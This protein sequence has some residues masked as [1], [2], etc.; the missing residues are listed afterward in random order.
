MLDLAHPEVSFAIQAGE[1]AGKLAREVQAELVTPALT[2]DDKSPVTVADYSVQALL[3]CLLQRAFPDDPLVGEEDAAA[4]REEK[5]L[6][7]LDQVV[8]FVSQYL[9]YATRETVCAWLDRGDSQPNRRFWTLD[10]IDGTKGFLRRDQYAIALALIVDGQVR[11][12]VLACPNLTDAIKPEPNGPG[13]LIV[14]VRG[15]GAWCRALTGGEFRELS[16]DPVANPKQARVLRS[17]ESGHT[18]VS[19]MDILLSA[20]GTEAEPVLMDSQAKYGV[21]ASGA[22]HLLLRLLSEKQPNYKEMIW[23]QAAGS[24]VI[25]EA[26]GRITDLAGLPLDFSAGRTLAKNSGIL[27]SNGALHDAA[28]AALRAIA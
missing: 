4:L 28:L 26:G 13:S 15:Q 16:I 7:T 8:R 17:F 23:D 21:L 2:K 11:L 24:I 12:G 14:A 22:G 27:A 1:L 25:E 19:R 20:L 6:E 10:P 3:S 5:N 9:A 18:N